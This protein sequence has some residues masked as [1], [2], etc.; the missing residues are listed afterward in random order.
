M[1]NVFTHFES[2][3]LPEPASDQLGIA[4][5]IL[6]HEDD[7]R[8]PSISCPHPSLLLWEIVNRK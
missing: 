3:P 8:V 6:N 2:G 1:H 5:V 7:G 4:P